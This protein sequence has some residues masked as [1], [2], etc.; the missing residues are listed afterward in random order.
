[1]IF[2]NR[3]SIPVSFLYF[4]ILFVVKFNLFTCSMDQLRIL[5]SKVERAVIITGAGISIESGLPSFLIKTGPARLQEP[6]WRNYSYM[7]LASDETFTRDPDI[8][9]EFYHYL[10]D[11]Y[12]NAIPN[13]AHY[14][15]TKAQEQFA[16]Q[17]RQ[18]S[19]ITT[20]FDRLHTRAGSK[21]VQEMYGSIFRTQCSLC[22]DVLV[23]YKQP[24]CEALKDR[25]SPDEDQAGDRIPREQLPR[26]RRCGG[27]LRPDVIWMDEFVNRTVITDVEDIMDNT[28]LC[29]V[30]GFSCIVHPIA[31]LIVRLLNAKIPVAEFN[32][33]ETELTPEAQFYFNGSCTETLPEALKL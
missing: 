32:I 29:L 14:A 30:V 3:Y 33:A 20:N 15:I 17:G 19:V 28:Q 2:L 22:E 5:L 23:N 31:S 13:K 12:L 7:Y 4:C 1:M 24:I 18:L 10:R 27:L 6:I 9:W 25:G 21:N 16:Q 11:V 8:V 26:C